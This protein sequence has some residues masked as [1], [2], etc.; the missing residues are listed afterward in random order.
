MISDSRQNHFYFAR[1]NTVINK[2]IVLRALFGAERK[3]VGSGATAE[4][5][6]E[7][8]LPLLP[9][10]VCLLIFI[11]PVS[12]VTLGKRWVLRLL[13]GSGIVLLRKRFLSFLLRT[14]ICLYLT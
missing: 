14:L 2:I 5:T 13:K 7:D 4:T 9:S 8:V 11:F 6:V 1:F 12:G 3:L 10:I